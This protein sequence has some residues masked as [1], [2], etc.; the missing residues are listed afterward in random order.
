MKKTLILFAMLLVSTCAWSQILIKPIFAKGD[1][2][3]YDHSVSTTTQQGQKK[4]QNMTTRY[5]V[6]DINDEGYIIQ[7]NFLDFSG[8][9]LPPT[10]GSEADMRQFFKSIGYMLQTDS[11]GS[12]KRIINYDEVAQKLEK[13]TN[14]YVDSMYN[15]NPDR[16]KTTGKEKFKDIVKDIYSEG[17]LIK[18]LKTNGMFAYYGKTL[19]TGDKEKQVVMGTKVDCTYDVIPFSD[20]LTVIRKDTVQMS[21]ED[22][23]EFVLKMSGNSV[24]TYNSENIEKMLALL[25]ALG[26]DLFKVEGTATIHFLPNGWLND[27]TINQ[28]FMIMGTE[29]FLQSRMRIK[30]KNF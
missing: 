28:H 21:D 9:T 30:S 13:K 6:D 3:V 25:K 11:T 2:A 26:G 15:N 20:T 23:K 1:T 18:L 27:Q 14:E 19:K 7:V 16:F 24:S 22:V 5:V 12:I 10:M 4:Y 17:N 8:N 29:M